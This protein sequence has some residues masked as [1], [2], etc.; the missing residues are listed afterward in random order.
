LPFYSPYHN[1]PRVRSVAFLAR[2]YDKA[3]T[4][5]SPP[6]LGCFPWVAYPNN[7]FTESARTPW[8]NQKAFMAA[9]QQQMKS[10]GDADM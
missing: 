8:A 1:L 6:P 3:L 9:L 10:D 2:V 5:L 7:A 4:T